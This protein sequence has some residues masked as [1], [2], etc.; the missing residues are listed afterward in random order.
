MACIAIAQMSRSKVE[1][2][3]EQCDKHIGII[4]LCQCIVQGERNTFRKSHVGRNI[5]EQRAGD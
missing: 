2:T 3:R 4:I 1:H 5:A